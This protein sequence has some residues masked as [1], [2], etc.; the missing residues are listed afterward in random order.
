VEPAQ[1]AD[2]RLVV[3]K[4]A[5]AVQFME[6]GEDRVHIVHRVGTLRMARDLRHLPR[7]QL[8]IDVLGELLALLV[9]AVDLFGDVDGGIVL[10]ETQLFNLGIELGNWLLK[11][12]ESCFS[13]CT[14]GV[15]SWPRSVMRG[16]SGRYSTVSRNA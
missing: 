11:I 4:G 14:S 10:H 3:G 12:E 16:G 8:G 7:S 6:I 15:M 2:D 9:Q 13:H 5:V 1:A